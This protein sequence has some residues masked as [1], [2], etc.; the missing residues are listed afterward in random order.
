MTTRRSALANNTADMDPKRLSAVAPTAMVG[1]SKHEYLPD[2][3]LE[4]ALVLASA[5]RTPAGISGAWHAGKFHIDGKPLVDLPVKALK[6]RVAAYSNISQAKVLTA[7]RTC[8]GFKATAKKD[9]AQTLL[10]R[11]LV[12]YHVAFR[13]PGTPRFGISWPG[14]AEQ[15]TAERRKGKGKGKAK[16]KS[17]AKPKSKANDSDGVG[18]DSSSDEGT[19]SEGEVQAVL[20]AAAHIKAERRAE[21]RKQ[22]IAMAAQALAANSDQ[23]SESEVESAETAADVA[24]DVKRKAKAR[25]QAKRRKLQEAMDRLDNDKDS[26]GPIDVSSA[27]DIASGEEE[28]PRARKV[29]GRR[30]KHKEGPPPPADAAVAQNAMHTGLAALL[31][32]LKEVKAQGDTT[33]AKAKASPAA[34]RDAYDKSSVAR[35]ANSGRLDAGTGFLDVACTA[36]PGALL[37]FEFHDELEKGKFDLYFAGIVWQ[38]SPKKRFDL[39]SMD[40]EV[41]STEGP[42]RTITMDQWATAARQYGNSLQNIGPG[43]GPLFFAYMETVLTF[44]RKYGARRAQYYDAYYRSKATAAGGPPNWKPDTMFWLE[45]FSAVNA[46]TCHCGSTEHLPADCDH[47]ERAGGGA[48][49]RNG[50]GAGAGHQHGGTQSAIGAGHQHGGAQLASGAPRPEHPPVCG[51]YNNKSCTRPGCRYQHKCAKCGGPHPAKDCGQGQRR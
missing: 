24:A 36:D 40:F 42:R 23:H 26:D 20:D 49:V 37:V 11:V 31:A 18:N 10:A 41:S 19:Q 4:A 35:A 1:N 46:V 28:H 21:R 51:A 13:T 15:D 39:A 6:A 14:D 30:R 34:R 32:Q 5:A 22:R 12:L 29:A 45:S 25:R 9:N 47:D 2:S 48:D 17:K 44:G 8:K 16:G 27:S 7:T 38:D 3:D 43:Q 33:A 50:A